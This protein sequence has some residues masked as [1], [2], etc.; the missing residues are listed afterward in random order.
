M[1]RITTI[2]IQLYSQ[3]C[4]AR[5]LLKNPALLALD[6]A[7]A[8][9]DQKTEALFQ[10]ILE[11]KFKDATIL[12]VAHRVETLRWCRTKIEIGSGKLLSISEINFAQLPVVHSAAHASTP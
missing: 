11:E 7:T 12:C 9:L 1:F 2:I 6:E 10:K 5:V 4:L 8:N 3:V